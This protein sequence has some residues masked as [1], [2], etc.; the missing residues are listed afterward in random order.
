M[1]KTTLARAVLHYPELTS[2]YEQRRL[3][4]PCDTLST[5]VQ[6]AA[7]IGAYIGLQP[8]NDLTWPVIHHFSSSPPSLLI[9][10][11]L[12]TIWE[13]AESRRDVEKFL[14]LLEEVEHLALIVSMVPRYLTRRLMESQITMRGAERPSN[15]RW[16]RPFLEPLKPLAQ[17]AA[18]QTFIDIVD[19]I[20]KPDDINKILLLADNMPLAINLLA[21]LVDSEG[22]PSVLGR[23]ETQRTSIVAEGYDATSNLELSISLSLSGPRMMSSPAALDLLSLLSMLPDGLSDVEL[24]QAQFPVENI[25]ACKSTLLRT[26][27]A[28]TDNQKRLKVL[29]PVREY[30]QKNNPAKSELIQP[31]SKHYQEL[32]QLYKKFGGTLSNAGLV[33]R[34]AA[35]LTNIQ[36]VMLQCLSSDRLHLAEII[37]SSCELSRYNRMTNRA[38]LPLLDRIQ[39]FLPL[40]V[41]H[42]LE[43]YVITE[44]LNGWNYWSNHRANQLIDQ[45]LEHFNHFDDPDMKCAFPQYFHS[46]V[47]VKT[48][49]GLFYNA[50]AQYCSVT[51]GPLT[52][53]RLCQSGLSLATSIGSP[54]RQALALQG[55]ALIKSKM[56]DFAGGTQDASESQSA[57][58]MTGNLFIEASGLWIE[59]LCCH[60]LGSYNYS[61]SLLDRATHLLDLCCMT[62]GELTSAIRT[63]QSEVYRLKSEYVDACNI[64]NHILRTYSSDQAPVVHAFALLNIA[65]IDVEIGGS[66]HDV[67][68]NIDTA[69]MLFQTVEF[70]TGLMFCDTIKAALDLEALKLS[71]AKGLLQ[72]CL[73]LAWGKEQDAVGYCLGKLASAP[74]CSAVDPL[75]FLVHSV[76]SKQILDLH[77][78]LQFL[79][80]V[81]Q[82][83]GDQETAVSLFTV[84]LNGFTKMD[85]HRSRA[86]CMVRLGD[87]SKENGDELKAAELWDTARPLFG[88][89]SQRK[90][91]ADLDSKLASLNHILPQRTQQGPVDHPS[92]LPTP[93]ALSEHL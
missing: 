29:V 48:A 44:Q 33:A 55:L 24:L 85:V 90:Q 9:L 78:A 65:Q 17:D 87:I 39:K 27:L 31:L 13:P 64:Q 20:H 15:V 66:E 4:V 21:H 84:A 43:A 60:H 81:F 25:R 82:G 52:A 50:A 61:L 26:S 46:F 2:R 37:S 63:S 1:G 22:I 75:S 91:L 76:K 16:T 86:E 5:N 14:C 73:S 10:D 58:K 38:H 30:V 49:V 69:R 19:D 59:A 28:Y 35:N 36:N 71:A 34:V 12:E 8:G 23:W 51:Q 54:I 70:S 72:K 7:L 67:Q 11:N 53:M 47:P 32:L 45:A 68:K 93:P 77:K 6:L 62:G 83:Q 92:E 41:D 56:G 89:S 40:P 74:Q 42:K 3:F 57:A 18:H 80:N 88:R 79:G